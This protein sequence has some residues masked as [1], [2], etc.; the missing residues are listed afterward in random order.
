MGVGCLSGL[1]GHPHVLLGQV[2]FALAPHGQARRG[3][4]RTQRRR[5]RRGGKPLYEVSA[6]AV[7]ATALAALGDHATGLEEEARAQALFQSD[8]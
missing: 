1:P 2:E 5:L 3:Q 6:R 7:A 4:L 8:L